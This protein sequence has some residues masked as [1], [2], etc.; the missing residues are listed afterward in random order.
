MATGNGWT[1]KAHSPERDTRHI[2]AFPMTI[3]RSPL[4]DGPK[5]Q[6]RLQQEE[7]RDLPTAA[8]SIA[9]A[10]RQLASYSTASHAAAQRAVS[11]ARAALSGMDVAAAA[12]AQGTTEE[13]AAALSGALEAVAAAKRAL[14]SHPLPVPGQPEGVLPLYC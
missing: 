8:E 11:A 5:Q 4:L 1:I 14:S 3:A 9:A 7:E 2:T 12:A 13:A 6:Q 10:K